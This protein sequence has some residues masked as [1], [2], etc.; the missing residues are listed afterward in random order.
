MAE[1]PGSWDAVYRTSRPQDLPWFTERLDPD[2][3]AAIERHGI[4]PD[5]GP[6]LDLGTGPGTVAIELAKRG[7]QVTA[8]D[9]AESAIRMARKRAG[10]NASRIQW[11]ATDLHAASF[12]QWFQAV[13]D[14][15][16]YHSL[17]A[18]ERRRYAERVPGWIRP[19]GHL[20]LK[21]FSPDEPGDW[22]PHRIPREEL[23]TAFQGQLALQGLQ[24]AEFPGSLGHT[25]RA[26]LAVYRKPPG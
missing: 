18:P 19:G 21:A 9:V 13:F 14:R 4:G 24:P 12:P 17:A 2:V 5:G 16:V 25:P 3:E 22:G 11:I 7:F 6:V 8:L 26:W 1:Q 20:L 10:R 15:G 23:E